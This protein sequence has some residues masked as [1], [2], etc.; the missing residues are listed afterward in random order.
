MNNNFNKIYT[1]NYTKIFYLCLG[2]SAG[3]EDIAE[4]LTQ[5]TFIKVWE[6]LHTFRN[7]AA[8]STW[9]YRIAVNT[10]LTH[11]RKVKKNIEIHS[12][13]LY[14]VENTEQFD[15]M[16]IRIE[17]LHSCIG[18]LKEIDRMIIMLVL[19]E[20]PQKEIA[21]IIDLNNENVRVKIHRIKGKLF[22]CIKS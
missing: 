14:G 22:K 5:E 7:L 13:H 18:K 6:K 1:E 10:C 12:E 20:L 2:Y 9:I 19:E 4:E 17:K 21:S 16:D 15:N 11:L 8:I 3:K